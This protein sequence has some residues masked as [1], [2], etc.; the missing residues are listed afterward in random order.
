ML[1]NRVNTSADALAYIVDCTLATVYN[2][3]VKKSK[4]K[5]EF[6]RQ[7]AI[8]QVGIDW[9]KEMNVDFST[10]RAADVVKEFSGN[11]QKWAEQ[12]MPE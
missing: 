8:A 6:N 2:M 9:M 7:I 12:F 3:A 4:Q 10:T 5:Y 1:K 11:V